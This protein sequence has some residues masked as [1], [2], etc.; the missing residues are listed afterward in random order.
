MTW[1]AVCLAC[2]AAFHASTPPSLCPL[3]ER[4]E[5]HTYAN[6]ASRAADTDTR[7]FTGRCMQEHLGVSGEEDA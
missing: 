3:C 5:D 7:R 2:G 4:R 6:D 1:P